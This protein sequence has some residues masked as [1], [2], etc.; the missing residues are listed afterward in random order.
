[1]IYQNQIKVPLLSTPKLGLFTIQK[2]HL[3]SLLK[4]YNSEENMRYISSGKHQWTE[5]ELE[6]KYNKILSDNGILFAIIELK[7]HQIIG[8]AGY[9]NSFQDSK[10]LELGYIIDSKYWGKGYGFEVCSALIEYGFNQLNL[11]EIIARMYADNTGSV[12]LSEKCGM[13]HLEEGIAPNQKVFYTY[14]IVRN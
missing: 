10:K 2:S 13:K 7:S 4:I 8:E 3:S 6:E 9:F 1:M 14:G 12:R 11:K 5:T